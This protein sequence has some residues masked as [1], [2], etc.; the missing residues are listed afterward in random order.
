M[1][2]SGKLKLLFF[3]NHFSMF[4]KYGVKN[5]LK[6]HIFENIQTHTSWEKV[7]RKFSIIY[8]MRRQKRKG[9][10]SPNGSIIDE[11]FC[12]HVNNTKR[13]ALQVIIKVWIRFSVFISCS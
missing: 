1:V 6:K 9:E 11:D 13:H 3:W 5:D 10:M 4:F 8:L 2:E 7:T 12:M